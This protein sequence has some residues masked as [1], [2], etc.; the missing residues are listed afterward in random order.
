[1]EKRPDLKRIES[2]R[3]AQAK[4]ISMAK[5]AFAPRLNAFGSWETDSPSPGWNG[6]NNWIA[7]AELQF[8]LFSGDSKR[9]N[10]A[11]QE[12]M[13]EKA[14]A[15]RDSYRNQV[16]LQVRKAYYDYD[17]AQQQVVVARTAVAQAEESLRINQN[18]YDGGLTTISDLLRVQESTQRTKADYWQAV[19]RV[20]TSYAGVELATGIISPSSPVVTQ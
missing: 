19:Y 14:V 20:Q 11:M 3:S 17:S 9:A 1:M 10:L 12:A 4:G 13:Q 2:E 6:G 8:D 16:R 7:G 18:R 5:G 15:M